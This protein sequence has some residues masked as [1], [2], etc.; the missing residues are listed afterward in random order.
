MVFDAEDVRTYK[1]A[2]LDAKEELVP[3]DAQLQAAEDVIDALLLDQGNKHC[4]KAETW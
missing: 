4:K 3:S 1:F 2:S